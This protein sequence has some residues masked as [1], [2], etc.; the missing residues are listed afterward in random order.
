M[1][2]IETFNTRNGGIVALLAQAGKA[3]RALLL[4]VVYW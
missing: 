2:R 3:Q 1:A 4:S